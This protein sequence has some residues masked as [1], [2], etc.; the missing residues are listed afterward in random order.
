[1][2]KREQAE[3]NRIDYVYSQRDIDNDAR[4]SVFEPSYL[5]T[6]QER[7][8]GIINLLK[9]ANVSLHAGTRAL[10][11]GGGS[12]KSGRWL[13]AMGVNPSQLVVNDLLPQRLALA[14]ETLP[15]AVTLMQGNAVELPFKEGE[16]DL[17]QQSV[18][19]SSILDETLR[20]QLAARMWSWLK[21]GGGILWYDFAWNNPQNS[22]V[23][24][25]SLADVK[26][27]FPQGN[28]LSRKVTL[29]PPI[30]R[31]VCRVHPSVYTVFNSIPLL[32]SHRLVWIG[33]DH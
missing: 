23:L 15:A 31:L 22:D 10:D 13:I 11:I 25:L 33:R 21:P 2:N 27:L 12:G 17:I 7:D 3:L 14:R 28:F 26:R 30:A 6:V 19:F 4:Y 1:M 20:E 29:A 9:R 18:V 16:L 8:R 32:R 24:G 5:Y